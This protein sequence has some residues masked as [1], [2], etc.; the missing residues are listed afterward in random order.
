MKAVSGTRGGVPSTRLDRP[1]EVVNLL[2]IQ[3]PSVAAAQRHGDE[4]TVVDGRPCP[5]A[6]LQGF[7]VLKKKKI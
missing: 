5:A 7:F 4:D 1:G 3:A 6:Y 2:N